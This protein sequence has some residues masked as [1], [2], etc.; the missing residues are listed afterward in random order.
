MKKKEIKQIIAVILIAI[1]S[2]WI[3]NNFN[4]IGN[5]INV[6]FKIIFPFILGAAF[7]FIFNIPMSNFEKLFRIIRKSKK[8]TKIERIISVVL[9]IF[10][11]LF[12]IFLLFKLIIPELINVVELLIEKLP[13]LST[14]AQSLMEKA[15]ENE[16]IRNVV[17][18]LKIDTTAINE[19][20]M[21]NGPTLL[22]S[23]INIITSIFSGLL[24]I[25][26][27]IVFAVYILLG[28]EKIKKFFKKMV[29][30]YLPRRKAIE[31]IRLTK[32]SK[33][34]FR[35]FVVGQFT[36]ACIIGILCIIGML[37]LRIPYA[38]T[39]GILVGATALIPILG[40]FL[41]AIVGA[42]L[43]VSINPMKALV[44]I[45]F[46]IVL[47][48]FEGKLI[49]PKVVGSSVGLPGILALFAVIVGGSIG[50]IAGI[51]VGLPI[52]SI[53]YT[54]LKE[55]INRRLENNKKI[56]KVN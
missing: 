39:I 33:I 15:L 40:A 52:V 3:L 27:G 24:N 13:Y 12:L 28:K 46:I 36:E 50:G 18:N 56:R 42:I 51:L 34:T 5:F 6:I 32:L 30:A 17:D 23:S 38:I 35:K 7:A 48:Q 10:I 37:I 11:I 41:G 21:G 16:N 2:Y 47:Q 31:T 26:L 19:T 55:D 20:I 14:Q 25:I 22:H 29:L 43:I 8:N 44:F 49:Y 9:S 1:I 53:I 4:L 54:V 45:V